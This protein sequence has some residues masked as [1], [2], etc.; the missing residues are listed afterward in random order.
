VADTH[1]PFRRRGAGAI[2]L[3]VDDD[4]ARA[5]L[6]VASALACLRETSCMG[7]GNL[8][9]ADALGDSAVVETGYQQCGF[10]SPWITWS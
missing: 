4:P 7:A 10:I 9:L 2:A 1:V 5:V 6:A 3:H 8:I